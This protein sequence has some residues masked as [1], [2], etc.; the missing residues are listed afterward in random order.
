MLDSKK[1]NVSFYLLATC[2]ILLSLG[3]LSIMASSPLKGLELFNDP[4]FYFKKQLWAMLF[5]FAI[6]LVIFV[7][8]IR[9]IDHLP[10]PLLAISL[11][12]L[13]LT[14][15]GGF[16]HQA[17]GAARWLKLFGVSVQSSELAK[18][19]LVFFLAKN[20]ARREVKL[21]RFGLDLC[22][23]LFV[24]AVMILLLMRQPDFG[25][26]ALLLALTFFMLFL[27]GLRKG[28][29]IKLALAFLTIAIVA[30]ISAPYRL[31]RLFSYLDPFSDFQNSGF[32]IIQSY[33]AFQNGGFWGVG[34][35]ESR[36]KLFFLPEAHT[37]FIL[38]VIGE[39]LGFFGT[40]LVLL[41]FFLILQLGFFIAAR[42]E[43]R[44]RSLLAQGLTLLITTQ[45]I[46]NIGVVSGAL[47]TKGI[48]LPFISSGVSSLLTFIFALSILARLGLGSIPQNESNLFFNRG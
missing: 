12:L 5:G 48:T 47:P 28:P 13:L 31:R 19:A 46:F 18:V 11:A 33:L 21:D 20:L 17:G 42:Q 32:Q 44:F 27:A 23:N 7:L 4:A 43:N 9:F 16:S 8:P 3:L 24:L 41:L 37:D 15:L 40:G 10:L 6:T 1:S 34:L 36:Q 26:A 38:A 30:M 45:A 22:S 25:T 39:E 35:G 2:F 14:G 29:L